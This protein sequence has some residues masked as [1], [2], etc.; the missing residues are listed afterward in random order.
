MLLVCIGSHLKSVLRYTFLGLDACHPA[1]PYLC[2]QG[3][4]YPWLF[5][6][7][8]R[9]PREKR[10][11]KQ[12]SILI[13]LSAVLTYL[14]VLDTGLCCPLCRKSAA[15]VNA[16][17]PAYCV[18]SYCNGRYRSLDAIVAQSRNCLFAVNTA[19]QLKNITATSDSNGI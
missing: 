7:A 16:L 11:G 10:F 17:Y 4:E 12:W 6:E 1:T 14:T 2:E 13:G 5:F 18:S 19:I 8:K 3:Y 9:G 15:Y